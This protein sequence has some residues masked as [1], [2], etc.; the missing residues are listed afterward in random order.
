MAHH[1]PALASEAFSQKV[2]KSRSREQ[3]PKLQLPTEACSFTHGEGIVG[4][5]LGEN[6]YM[7]VYG[8]GRSLS[9]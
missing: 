1:C 6:E 8:W 4:G 9:S 3:L 2:L 7:Y 5:R